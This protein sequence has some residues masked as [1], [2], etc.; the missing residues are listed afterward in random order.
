MNMRICALTAYLS[1]AAAAVSFASGSAPVS[2]PTAKTPG[3]LT[4]QTVAKTSSIQNADISVLRLFNRSGDIHLV[5]MNNA[6]TE[7]PIVARFA[8]LKSPAY[9][10][11]V[12]GS[13]VR[14]CD[15][16][17]LEA[18]IPLKL[19]PG[20]LSDDR[21]IIQRI[22]DRCTPLIV[23][24][25]AAAMITPGRLAPSSDPDVAVALLS[26][27]RYWS[28]IADT[29]IKNSM[30]TFVLLNAREKAVE[31]VTWKVV[32]AS[33]V[34]SATARYWKSVAN[35]R[36]FLYKSVKDSSLRSAAIAAIT[37]IV[38]T[39]AASGPKGK[40][41]ISC[42]VSNLSETSMSG[43]LVLIN[44]SKKTPLLSTNLPSVQRGQKTTRVFRLANLKSPPHAGAL[45]VRAEIRVGNTMFAKVVPVTGG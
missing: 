38:L 25:A 6:S 45:S 19:H 11:Y 15:K 10:V 18:G 37:P 39:A 28:T 43:K 2:T 9:D 7:Q 31:G 44:T 41:V 26:D 40:Q 29:R 35:Q 36:G 5:I 22:I 13:F 30:A 33:E 3:V 1:I 34:I 21:P 4:I 14:V 12:E 32:P 17:E 42:Q 8:E 20:I 24:G 23:P 27:L 16:A